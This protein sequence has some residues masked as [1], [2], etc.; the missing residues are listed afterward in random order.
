MFEDFGKD[1]DLT[2][3]QLASRIMAL[4]G[5]PLW[6]TQHVA[7]LSKLPLYPASAPQA[8]DHLEALV[9]S[10]AGASKQ[11]PLAMNKAMQFGDHATASVLT[12][13]T[14]TLDA[15]ASFI[16]AHVP[17]DWKPVKEKRAAS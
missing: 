3:S 8:I 9:T 17:Q 7:K 12:A 4:G 6:T 14:K 15:Q 16:A 10:Y 1:L 5:T 2:A 13:Y 11:I